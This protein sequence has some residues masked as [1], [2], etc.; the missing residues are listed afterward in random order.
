ML[1]CPAMQRFLHPYL[2][3]ELDARDAVDIQAHLD[4]C[5]DCA[6]LYRSEKLFLDLLKTSLRHPVAPAGLE[7]KVR[8]ALAED[9]EP[10]P[11]GRRIRFVLAPAAAVLILALVM[12]VTTS[13]EKKTVPELLDT[14]VS[15]HQLYLAKHLRLD[16]ES[17]DPARVSRW[18]QER[19]GFPVSLAQK[20]VKHLRLLGGRLVELKG[21]K[22]V[23]VAYEV[24]GRPL[25]LVMTT[26][27]GVRLFGTHE[28]AEKQA[29]FYQSSYHGFQTLSWAL[30]GLA[31]VFVSDAQAL[32]KRACMICHTSGQAERPLTGPSRQGISTFPLPS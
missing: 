15:T 16:V 7:G 8:Q 14:A 24:E 4:G 31:Y 6:A 10:K 29:R 2:D 17:S 25:S 32:N 26:A 21:R 18:L 5:P 27:Q 1:D 11:A 19:A 23:F 22:A 12:L 20:P 3:G 9:G 28:M 30:E 13:L